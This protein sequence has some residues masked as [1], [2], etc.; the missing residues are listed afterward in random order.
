MKHVCKKIV[1]V[2]YNKYTGVKEINRLGKGRK[3]FSSRSPRY[4]PCIW[5]VA[6]AFRKLLLH[7]ILTRLDSVR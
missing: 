4:S 2:R 7:W 5:L 3:E 6:E 1:V